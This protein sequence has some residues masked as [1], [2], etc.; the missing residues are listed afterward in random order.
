MPE[1]ILIVICL[2]NVGQHYLSDHSCTT[3]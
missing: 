3:L 2:Q 1:R